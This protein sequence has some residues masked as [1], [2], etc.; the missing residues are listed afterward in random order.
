MELSCFSNA[1]SK[2]QKGLKPL[3]IRLRSSLNVSILLT[4]RTQNPLYK[5]FFLLPNCYK[6][7]CV[8]Y[9]I[10]LKENLEK[11]LNFAD[12]IHLTRSD[13]PYEYILFQ[14]SS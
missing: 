7:V 9:T 8:G 11:F 4:K 6:I 10:L 14:A 13:N 2:R 1:T 12:C 3:F 5:G